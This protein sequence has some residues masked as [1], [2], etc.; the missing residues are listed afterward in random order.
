M[1]MFQFFHNTLKK[2]MFI[3][4]TTNQYQKR[5]NEES[6]ILDVSTFGGTSKFSLSPA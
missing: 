6:T 2:K 4:L 1:T 5:S 3:S